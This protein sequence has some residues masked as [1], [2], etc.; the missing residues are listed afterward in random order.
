VR[1]DHAP[2]VGVVGAASVTLDGATVAGAGAVSVAGSFA[3][4]LDDAALSATGE[5]LLGPVDGTLAITLDAVALAGVGTVVTPPPPRPLVISPDMAW[6]GR[7]VID[8]GITQRFLDQQAKRMRVEI[9][10]KQQLIRDAQEQQKS[11]EEKERQQRV[12]WANLPRPRTGDLD[13][14]LERLK[15]EERAVA[16][17]QNKQRLAAGRKKLEEKRKRRK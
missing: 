8:P 7:V 3:I 10:L 6:A 12:E 17:M 5:V 2:A 9:K 11:I 4:A 1:H 15:E 16:R 13:Y 14:E